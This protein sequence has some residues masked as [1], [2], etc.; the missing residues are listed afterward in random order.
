M[1]Y[2]AAEA[3]KGNSKKERKTGKYRIVTSFFV[4]LVTVYTAFRIYTDG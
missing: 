2:S 1:E 3:V 4:G